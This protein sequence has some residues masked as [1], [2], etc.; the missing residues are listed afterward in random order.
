MDWSICLLYTFKNSSCQWPTFPPRTTQMS[1]VCA[2]VWTRGPYCCHRS[3]WC[4]WPA[5]PLEAIVM[6][7][8][9]LPLRAMSGSV[10][11]LQPESVL[12]TMAHA[13]TKGHVGVRGLLCSLWPCWCSRALLQSEAMLMRVACAATWGHVDI[14]GLPLRASPASIVLLHLG[15]VSVVCAVTRNRVEA[16]DTCSCWLW[17][18]RRL[19]LLWYPWLSMLHWEGGDLE[20]F[21][22]NP[23]PHLQHLPKWNNLDMKPLKRILK[24]WGGAV[25]V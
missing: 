12:M 9:V 14:R 24:K 13:T 7:V 11:L 3:R 2:A 21:C 17:R 23:Y 20:G 25:E 18:A 22:D 6:P 5:L 10:V 1:L 16:H 19:L 4:E 8:S 15:A